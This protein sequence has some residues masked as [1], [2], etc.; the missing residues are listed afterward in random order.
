MRVEVRRSRLFMFFLGA[1]IIIGVSLFLVPMNVN[2]SNAQGKPTTS[3]T[4]R[5]ATMLPSPEDTP[6]SNLLT[7]MAAPTTTSG[8]TSSA[9]ARDV[10]TIPAPSFTAS[11]PPLS[12]VD[13]MATITAQ[14]AQIKALQDQVTAAQGD[15]G[16]TLYAVVIIVIGLLLAFAVFFGLKHTAP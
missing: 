5:A 16:P 2:T 7:Q 9:V 11:V 1:G 6:F 8:P 15:K 4:N 13:A 14:Q 10:T 3:I 12:V